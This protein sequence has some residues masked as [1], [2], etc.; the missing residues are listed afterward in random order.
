MPRMEL[1]EDYETSLTVIPR[2]H[3][4]GLEEERAVLQR[5]IRV[6]MTEGGM[7]SG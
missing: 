1:E 3:T 2:V 6:L 5:E 4:T 7:D